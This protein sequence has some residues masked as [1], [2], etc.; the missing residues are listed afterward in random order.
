MVMKWLIWITDLLNANPDLA[1]NELLLWATFLKHFW[2]DPNFNIKEECNNYKTL[3]ELMESQ[4]SDEYE[5]ESY[6]DLIRKIIKKWKTDQKIARAQK[7]QC[8]NATRTRIQANASGGWADAIIVSFTNYPA[9]IKMILFKVKSKS[10]NWLE[11]NLY[12][13][14]YNN[15]LKFHTT[16]A[17]KN[18]PVEII[19]LDTE[20]WWQ[21]FSF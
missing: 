9:C 18:E 12:D 16:L 14:K 6:A 5:Y 20:W 1:E 15:N 21:K 7:W 4:Y 8:I 13:E 3:D 11:Y 2:D 10:W 19:I 17:H